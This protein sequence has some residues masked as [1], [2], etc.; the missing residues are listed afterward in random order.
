MSTRKKKL[1]AGILSALVAIVVFASPTDASYS[2]TPSTSVNPSADSSSIVNATFIASSTTT[3]NSGT[4]V[5]EQVYENNSLGTTD[6]LFQ[7]KNTGS[8]SA[9]ENFTIQAYAGYL[10]TVGYETDSPSGFS[11]GTVAPATI[12]RSADGNSLTFNFGANGIVEGSTSE[13]FFVQ[14]NAL[15]YNANGSAITQYYNSQFQTTALNIYQ[16]TG[17]VIP[18]P[19]SLT[20]CGIGGVVGLV[21]ARVRRKKRSR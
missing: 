8:V 13:V 19:S 21:Y 20:L 1:S 2:L 6:F 18:E 12:S 3:D 9:L 17:A 10:T 4:S 15:D 7:L 14:T 5:T 16:P 11:S